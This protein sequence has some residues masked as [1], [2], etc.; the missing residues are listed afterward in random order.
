M[1]MERNQQISTLEKNYGHLSIM[2]NWIGK[3]NTAFPLNTQKFPLTYKKT[4]KSTKKKREE[5]KE[6][7]RKLKGRNKEKTQSKERE[8]PMV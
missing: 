8:Q 6:G 2:R 1:K 5:G 3:E 4:Y 7:G